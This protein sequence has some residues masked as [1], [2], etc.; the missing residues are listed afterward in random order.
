[1]DYSVIAK[2]GLKSDWRNTMNRYMRKV[3]WVLLA[4]AVLSGGMWSGTSA[5]WAKEKAGTLAQQVQRSWALASLYVEQDGKKIEPFGS[6]PRG[7]MLLS[8]DGRFSII[9]MRESLPKFA[10]NSRVKGAVEENQAVV[11]GSLATYGR[12]T[13]V[14]EKEH[15]MNMHIEGSTFPNWDGEDQKRVWTI[16]GDELKVTVPKATIGGVSHLIWKRAK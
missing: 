13:V 9:L 3:V 7:S 14:S 16:E 15:I 5:V 11:Q 4:V 6:E 2:N 10:A 1:M 12:Y 8:S